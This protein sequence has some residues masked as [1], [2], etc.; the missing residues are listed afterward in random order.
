MLVYA[1][2][3]RKKYALIL[4]QTSTGQNIAATGFFRPFSAARFRE[5]K[6]AYIGGRFLIFTNA[7]IDVLRLSA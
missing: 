6:Q 7:E 5:N 4:R 2:K 3:R 1:G